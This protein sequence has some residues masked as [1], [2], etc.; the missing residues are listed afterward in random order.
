MPR[1]SADELAQRAQFVFRGTVQKQGAATMS[2]VPVTDKTLVVHV[3]EV[4][5]APEVLERH[6]GENIT[7]QLSRRHKSLEEGK[8]AIFYTN[9]WL[10]G[11][12]IAVQSVGQQSVPQ[13]RELLLSQ[14]AG[15]TA[16]PPEALATRDLQKR[17][18]EA[19]TVVTGRVTEVRLPQSSGSGGQAIA[20]GGEEG[21]AAQEES[22][23]LNEHD[24][25]W[26]EA[27]VEVEQVE[28]GK[29]HKKQIVVRF[30]SSEDVMWYRAPKFEAGQEGVFL[31]HEDPQ[32]AT[33]GIAADVLGSPAEEVYMALDPA[34]FQPTQELSKVKALIST[35]TDQSSEPT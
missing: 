17:V 4:L 28:K 2:N 24:A 31:L 13:R 7:V 14:P 6:A 21:I 30:P 1:L 23:P 5:Q 19:Q 22:G 26:R 25:Q 33:F 32:P 18:A 16:T 29:T 15:P 27:V 11:D 3:D 34:D 10:F 9:G 20:A 8:E 12:S 35:E